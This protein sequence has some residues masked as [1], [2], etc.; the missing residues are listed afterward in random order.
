MHGEGPGSD[1]RPAADFPERIESR[2]L[3]PLTLPSFVSVRCAWSRR[4]APTTQPSGPRCPPAGSRSAEGRLRAPGLGRSRG[5]LTS[6]I[7]LPCDAVGRP[8][9]FAVTGGNANGCTQ[10]T[11]V[12]QA[13]RVPR[14]GPGRPRVRPDH[15]IGDEGYRTKPYAAGCGGATSGT[16]PG[17]VRPGPR[18]VPARQPWRTSAGLQ[19]AHPRSPADV[20]VTCD[21]N[22]QH[23]S[24]RPRRPSPPRGGARVSRWP[25]VESGA[26]FVDGVLQRGRQACDVP[27][28]G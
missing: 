19:Q 12:M 28:G 13:I 22:S 3:R 17:T 6:R 15:V 11:A 14:P 16:P 10:F 1:L 21:D 27:L 7:H 8:L 2:P 24:G 23:P 9:A 20:G 5:G 26:E 25:G 18:Q 4:S